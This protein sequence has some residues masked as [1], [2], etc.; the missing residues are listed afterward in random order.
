MTAASKRLFLSCLLGVMGLLVACTPGAGVTQVNEN[1]I[2]VNIS[3]EL[4]QA[5]QGA[6]RV[7][8]VP[9]AVKNL[10]TQVLKLLMSLKP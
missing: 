2:S 8:Q 5:I 10:T 9:K 6:Q 4:I 3:E 7:K 1:N